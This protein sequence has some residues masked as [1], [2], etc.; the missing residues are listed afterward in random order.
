M[1]GKRVG[2]NKQ[3]NFNLKFF[4]IKN[5]KKKKKKE[6][7]IFTYAHINFDFFLFF[8]LEWNFID[9]TGEK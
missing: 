4:K 1:R 9:E 3:T 7:F 5:K 8:F 2:G 6:K